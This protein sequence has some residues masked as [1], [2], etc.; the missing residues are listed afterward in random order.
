M[1]RVAVSVSITQALVEFIARELDSGRYQTASEVVRAALY[2]LNRL[3]IQREQ[4]VS[5]PVTAPQPAP[6]EETVH[7]DREKEQKK[8]H[9]SGT[10]VSG[11]R[12]LIVE[13]DVMISL[14]LHDIATDLGCT[15]VGTATRIPQAVALLE[16]LRVDVA[17]LDINL[18]GATADPIANAAVTRGVPIVFAT[19]Y[20]E[21]GVPAHLQ[22]WPVIC[23]PYTAKDVERG[24]LAAL[25]GVSHG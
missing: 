2:R 23:K 25:K 17:I 14:T 16:D 21:S 13:D 6:A 9:P 20:G 22:D 4:D 10:T 12:I 15:V 8:N 5:E 18:G 3:K 1:A 7:S 24:I 11:T 19:G